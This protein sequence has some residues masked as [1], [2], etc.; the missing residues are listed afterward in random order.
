MEFITWL[1]TSSADPKKYS[2]MVQGSGLLALAYI[3]QVGQ[4]TCDFHIICIS[5]DGDLWKSVV[6]SIASIVE[7]GLDIVGAIAFIF[8]VGR[9]IWNQRWSAYTAQ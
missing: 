7:W 1:V 4:I 6:M 2:T 3:I 9:K 8:G 5:V